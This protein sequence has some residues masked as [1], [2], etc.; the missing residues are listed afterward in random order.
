MVDYRK[1]VIQVRVVTEETPSDKEMGRLYAALEPLSNYYEFLIT[2]SLFEMIPV[3]NEIS[4]RTEFEYRTFTVDSFLKL[5]DPKT[6]RRFTNLSD[7]LNFLGK[8][9]WS[10]CRQIPTE[11]TIIFKRVKRKD[12]FNKICKIR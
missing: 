8:Y 4:E 11:N 2:G 1:P 6:K 5:R 7:R 9:G 10:L 12:D 3:L